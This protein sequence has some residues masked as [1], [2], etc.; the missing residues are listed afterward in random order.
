MRYFLGPSLSNLFA[1][2]HRVRFLRAEHAAVDT[3]AER[4]HAVRLI[5]H[6]GSRLR[7]ELDPL[8]ADEA[9]RR[10]D[11]DVAG[12][13]DAVTIGI[14]L[15]EVGKELRLVAVDLHRNGALSSQDEHAFAAS[16]TSFDNAS[17]VAPAISDTR[18]PP[19]SL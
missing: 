4:C 1:P 14:D 3:I 16:P 11:L 15:G 2:E 18:Q 12:G 8:C 5:E 9:R 13:D 19:I 7:I 17:C 6:S 10:A